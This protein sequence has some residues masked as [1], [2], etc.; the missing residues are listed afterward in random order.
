MLMC[1]PWPRE[2]D[3]RLVRSAPVITAPAAVEY[4]PIGRLGG[5]SRASF[6][7]AD[8]LLRMGR[9]AYEEAIMRGILS[10]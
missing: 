1:A 10:E 5:T 6:G 9:S 7:G 3:K 4:Q 2:R 8:I